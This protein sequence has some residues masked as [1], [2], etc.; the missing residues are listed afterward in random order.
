[1][2]NDYSVTRGEAVDAVSRLTA[3]CNEFLDAFVLWETATHF[4]EGGGIKARSMEEAL[5]GFKADRL[6][7]AILR[8]RLFQVTN[9]LADRGF[10]YN[11]EL[12]ADHQENTKRLARLRGDLD[13]AG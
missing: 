3:A 12:T 4:D 11:E 5:A 7:N 6:Q 10:V 8:D 13:D 2:A 1:M 9:R